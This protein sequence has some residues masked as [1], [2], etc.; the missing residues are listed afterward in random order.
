MMPSNNLGVYLDMV[1]DPPD[2]EISNAIFMTGPADSIAGGQAVTIPS[3]SS[4]EAGMGPI[5]ASTSS[6]H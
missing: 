2:I 5:F 1:V 6:I 4:R 3:F